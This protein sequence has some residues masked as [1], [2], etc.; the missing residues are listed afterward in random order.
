MS[1]RPAKFLRDHV[2]PLAA[3]YQNA[4]VAVGNA[5]T[6]A[7]AGC[8]P[9]ELRAV[10]AAIADLL[11]AL[12]PAF[13]DKDWSQVYL[14]VDFVC[15]RLVS[16]MNAAKE[17]EQPP[18]FDPFYSDLAPYLI[19]NAIALDSHL[20]E[21]HGINMSCSIAII[22]ATLVWWD[23]LG[24]FPGDEGRRDRLRAAVSARIEA[25]MRVLDRVGDDAHTAYVA[26]LNDVL[27]PPHN[28]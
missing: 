7:R 8:T 16:A 21:V 24:Q 12:T 22:H 18:T 20:L 6:P 17:R 10:R 27:R 23:S 4:V 14:F 1:E 2:P 3:A 19:E 5:V 28:P 11:S 13:E 15:S 25:Y 9:D 26:I